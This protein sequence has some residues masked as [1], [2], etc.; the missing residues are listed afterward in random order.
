MGSTLLITGQEV[1][2]AAR[3]NTH[4]GPTAG[5]APG[6]IQA[7]LIV[8]PSKY[9][10]DFRSLCQRNPVPCPLLAESTKPGSWDAM[11]SCIPNITSTALIHPG[12][13]L[14]LRRDIPRYLV[15]RDGEID[16]SARHTD[17]LATWRDD[18]HVA[19][20]I[21]CSFSFEAALC[22]AGL[23]PGHIVGGRNVPMYRTTIPLNPAGV[24]TG[25]TYVVSMR[26]YKKHDVER[27]RAITAPYA[28]THG[29][30]V[31]WGWESVEELGLADIMKP[32][33]GDRPLWPDGKE[34][35]PQDGGAGRSTDVVPVFW[36]CGVTPQ[37]AVV[38]ARLQGTVMA[39]APGHMLVLDCLDEVLKVE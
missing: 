34:L 13:D 7:N 30:P 26:L 20:L 16:G 8:L 36:G 17:L 27:V 9:A 10:A 25:G 32:E 33:W 15:Y 28:F 2:Q 21:G 14:D 3:A 1:R 24:F 22:D 31:A 29:E 35:G 23:A 39:H 5:L 19:F 37:E 38:R 18:D 6:Y 4:T 11:K 12:N